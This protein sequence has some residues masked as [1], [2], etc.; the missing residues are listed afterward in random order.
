MQEFRPKQILHIH[1]FG[2]TEI[3]IIFL[4]TCSRKEGCSPPSPEYNF[5]NLMIY[6]FKGQYHKA[7]TNYHND[8]FVSFVAAFS[9]VQWVWVE[10]DPT[11]EDA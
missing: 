2:C 11:V 4:I 3:T 5:C 9:T 10:L 7:F 1:T 6:T 8:K